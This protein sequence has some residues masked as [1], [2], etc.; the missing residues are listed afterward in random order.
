MDKKIRNKALN[1]Y[2]GS[3]DCI[4]RAMKIQL[5]TANNKIEKTQKNSATKAH[6]AGL[7]FIAGFKGSCFFGSCIENCILTSGQINVIM[8]KK[9]D[10]E[11]SGT[12]KNRL[13][14]FWLYLKKPELF[15]A[16]LQGEIELLLIQAE[17]E[18]A[19][20]YLRLDVFSEQNLKEQYSSKYPQI[21][22]N[23]YFKR[24][25]RLLMSYNDNELN[26]YSWNEGSKESFI[27]TAQAR[28]IPIACVIPNNLFTSIFGKKKGKDDSVQKNSVELEG[29]ILVNGDKSDLAAFDFVDN[30]K[31]VISLLS[32]KTTR[33]APKTT[34]FLESYSKL[35]NH[36]NINN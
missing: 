21:V 25:E 22:F 23:D 9:P 30:G 13:A 12:D 27:K 19:Q 29:C 11:L 3:K 26:I 32:K 14:R 33:N 28:Q 31:P 18:S 35:F 8:S 17:S 15:H 5:L 24:P 4:A 10:S 2:F 20:L 36:L 6:Y 16:K 7:E 1:A 34:E